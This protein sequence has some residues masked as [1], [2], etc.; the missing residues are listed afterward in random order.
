MVSMAQTTARTTPVLAAAE[1]ALSRRYLRLIER[2]I[3]T[4]VE[5]FTPWPERP[6]CGHF[7]GGCHWY[8]IETIGPALTFALVSTSPEYDERATGVS[9][10]ELQ[11]MAIQG[12]RYLC[13]TH[14]T[15]PAECVR[16]AQGLGR[17]ENMGTKW[18]ERGK[19]FFRE[20]QCGPI[21]AE[22]GLICLLLRDQVDEETWLMV[23]RVHEDYAER[24]GAMPPRSGVYWDTQMEENA[25]TACGITATSLFLGRHEQAADWAAMARRWMF[26]VAATPQD[27][28]DLGAVG[29]TTAQALTGRTFTT[30]PDYW[31]ENHGM[32]HPN[33]TSTALWSIVNTGNLLHMWGE[34]L[35][36]ELFWNRRRVYENIKLVTDGAGYY[37]PVQG[38]DWHFLP[39]TGNEM[40]HAVAAVY[41]D[42]ADAAALQLRGLRN[43]E[44]RL[45]GNNGRLYDRDFA[46]RA[47]DVQD[48]MIMR[49]VGIKSA[50][51][52]YLLHRLRGPGPAPTPEPALEE[53]LAGV[54]VYPHAGFAFHRHASGQTSFAWR[55]AIMALPL[56]RDG[57]YLVAPATGSYLGT[58]VV[59]GQPDSHR[60]QSV[61]VSEG[62]DA[63]AAALVVDRCQETV[64]Q[65][66]LFASL[67][68]GRVLS[69]ERFT[70]LQ[71]VTVEALDQGYLRITNEHYPQVEPTSRGARTFYHPGG[72]TEFRGWLGDDPSDDLSETYSHPAWVNVDDRLG[73]RFSATGQTIYHNRHFHRPYHA[74]SDNLVLSRLDG[75]RAVS[76]GEEIA[77]LAALVCPGQEHGATAATRLDTT[78]NGRDAIAL[79]TDGYLAAANFGDRRRACAFAFPRPAAL[80]LYAGATSDA[81]GDTFTVT[82]VLQ[83]A[84]AGLFAAPQALQVAGDVRVHLTAEGLSYVT[85][86]GAS[87]AQ[88]VTAAGETVALQPG[89]TWTGE[90]GG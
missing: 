12:V 33:Y 1:N 73:I 17:P 13:F 11:R 24:F 16:P 21:V 2:W 71:D 23:A 81:H 58:P 34:E 40:P 7:F 52:M 47:H 70:A 90:A 67:P 89:E 5:Y 74:I 53:R 56:T 62:D 30:L 28:K 6:N 25:W 42:D 54:H 14:D 45:A 4:G 41:F 49:E 79:A 37:Q 51:D 43:T 32:V 77:S 38:M 82:L 86:V 87:A 27:A 18:G 66:A 88:I 55:N 50:A 39:A 48:P 9:R 63:F 15:G 22:M 84:S 26:S 68:D 65:E 72:A 19:G 64:R 78:H 20:S 80:P 31:A 46:E 85:N 83:G 35:P 3:P 76:A 75:E 44:L 36:P 8:G 10:A 59:N 61:R 69:Y 60:L 57:I 29:G